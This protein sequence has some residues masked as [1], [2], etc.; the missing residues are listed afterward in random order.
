MNTLLLL[1]LIL[2]AVLGSQQNYNEGTEIFG[3]FHHH[4]FRDSLITNILH[5]NS[6]FIP[7][8]NLHSQ[9]KIAL[10]SIVSLG[11]I[12]GD[13]YFMDLDKCIMTY[14][15]QYDITEYFHL[16]KSPL[17]STYSPFLSQ[18]LTVT[19]LFTVSTV[20]PF[21]E[22]LIVRIAYYVAFSDSFFKIKNM[23]FRFIYVF[24]QFE[25]AHF[26]LELNNLFHYMNVPQF[27]YPLTY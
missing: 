13:A 5:Q 27:I 3:I 26:F 9:S 25:K 19:D 10:K 1:L 16:P 15:R 7:G 6:T 23:N 14:S 11:L 4:T 21:I 18:P 17:W 20:L 12:P 22:Y 24:L 8:I 2:S